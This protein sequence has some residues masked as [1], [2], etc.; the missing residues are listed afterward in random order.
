MPSK[1]YSILIQLRDKGGKRSDGRETLRLW[2][3]IKNRWSTMVLSNGNK[4]ESFFKNE[5]SAE[6]SVIKVNILKMTL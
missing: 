6:Y 1:V 5:I 3:N 4:F 2:E